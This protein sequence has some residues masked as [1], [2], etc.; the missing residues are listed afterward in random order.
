LPKIA[1]A[2]IQEEGKNTII[3]M[4]ESIDALMMRPPAI[5][6]LTNLNPA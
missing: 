1:E 5:P 2:N 6:D 3:A 4:P